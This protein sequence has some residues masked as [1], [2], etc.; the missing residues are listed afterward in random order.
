GPTNFSRDWSSDV[1]SSD[2]PGDNTNLLA[3]IDMKAGFYDD[4]TGLVGDIG[5]QSAQIQ[6]SAQASRSLAQDAQQQRDSVS[7]VNQDEEAKIGRASCREAT[8]IATRH[9]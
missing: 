9:L 4:Y 6:A 2:L 1:C 5:I 7:G 3:V 8:W